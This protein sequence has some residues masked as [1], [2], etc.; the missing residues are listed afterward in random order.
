MGPSTPSRKQIIAF[1]LIMGI[2]QISGFIFLGTS[3]V[4]TLFTDGLSIIANI[5][6]IICSLTASRRG[7][8]ASRIFWLLFGS[9]FALLLIANVGWAICRYFNVTIA[10]G[11]VFPSLFYRL[12]AVPMAITLFLSDDIHTS[13]L[14]TFLDSC[15]VVGLVGLGMYQIQKAELKVLDPNM[16]KLI[17][18]ATVV[19]SVLVLAAIGRFFCYKSGRLRSLYG[20]LA[21]Y[22]SVYS[23]ISFLTSYFDAFLPRIAACF[24]LIWILT[25]LTAAALAITWCPSA[26]E[27]D[28]AELRISR[29]AALLC[30][31]LSMAIMVLGSA[32]LGLRI[33]DAS[34]TVGLVAVGLVLFSYTVRCALMQD[35]QEKYVAALKESNTRFEYISLATN[36]VLWDHNLAD[37]SVVWNENVCSLFGYRPAEVGA[38]NDWWISNVHPEDREHM[39]SNVRA[40]LESEKNS[41]A[42]EYRL[43]KT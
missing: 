8:G 3:P 32:A 15:I 31:N 10:E 28:R 20:R 1:I 36:D 2:L 35:V 21:I 39:L 4:G 41:W 27:G 29:R 18:T 16:G 37:G 11:A 13:K 7:R 24:D 6:A 25:Y 42:G 38:D 9:A 5:L 14:E 34:R 22:L 23:F 12:Y 26:T 43:R 30:F 40:V 17:T 33:V 19:N